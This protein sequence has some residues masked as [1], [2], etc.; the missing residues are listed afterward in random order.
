MNVHVIINESE[1]S[2]THALKSIAKQH[3]GVYLDASSRIMSSG[4]PEDILKIANRPEYI[5][6]SKS[7]LNEKQVLMRNHKIKNLKFDIG[8]IKLSREERKCIHDLIHER[9]SLIEG[10]RTSRSSSRSII[11]KYVIPVDQKIVDINN[12]LETIIHGSSDLSLKQIKAMRPGQLG[13]KDYNDQMDDIIPDTSQLKKLYPSTPYYDELTTYQKEKL[14]KLVS[15]NESLS[16]E[17]KSLESKKVTSPSKSKKIDNAIDKLRKRLHTIMVGQGKRKPGIEEILPASLV[18]INKLRTAAGRKSLIGFDD[19]SQGKK[20]LFGVRTGMYVKCYD[21]L[22][23]A[24]AER[25]KYL[26]ADRNITIRSIEI[27]NSI[28]QNNAELDEIIPGSFGIPL[29]QIKKMSTDRVTIQKLFPSFLSIDRDAQVKYLR[30]IRMRNEKL[31]KITQLEKE[32]SIHESVISKLYQDM[33]TEFRSDAVY[34]ANSLYMSVYPQVSVANIPKTTIWNIGYFIACSP[35]STICIDHLSD[36]ELTPDQM[37]N[38]ATHL[39]TSH[40]Q[41]YIY[42]SSTHPLPFLPSSITIISS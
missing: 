3:N 1:R 27:T 10:R 4:T 12:Q 42:I 15:D 14:A 21:E 35:N 13:I 18:D 17:L 23:A 19:L 5:I 26:S 28:D 32:M 40:L 24:E 8:F 41:K 30:L 7:D 6:A 20:V 25:D 36:T 34:F 2:N 37:S 29:S 11:S 9:E 16:Y 39:S 22:Q 33:D 38:L 31:T